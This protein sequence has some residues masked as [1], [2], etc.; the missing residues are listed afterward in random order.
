MLSHD[1]IPEMSPNGQ[2]AELIVEKMI[3]EGLLPKSRKSEVINKICEGKANA[4]NW[5]L[6]AED[7]VLK[8]EVSNE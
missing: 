6:W 5:R 2:L 1:S 8:P 3:I 4:S 7:I